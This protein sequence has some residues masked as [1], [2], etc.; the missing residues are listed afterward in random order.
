MTE[1]EIIQNSVY[2]GKPRILQP[3]DFL[4]GSFSPSGPSDIPIVLPIEMQAQQPA[5][6]AHGGNYLKEALD[7]IDGIS[8]HGSPEFLWGEIKKVDGFPI[9][10]GTS[11]N[12]ILKTMKNI[13]ICSIDLLPNNVNVSL[14]SYA[15]A[16]NIT[17]AMTADAANHKIGNYAFEN[18]PFTWQQL[19]QCISSHKA[20]LML[21][22]VGNEFYV[23]KDGTT[24]WDGGKILPLDPS[25]VISS[26]HFVLAFEDQDHYDPDLIYFYN[27]WSD[28]WG[29]KGLG[30]FDQN[31]LSRVLEIGTAVNI[32]DAR[33][34]TNLAYGMSGPQIKILQLFLISHGYSIPAG[35][36]GYYGQQ[37][38]TAIAM[39]QSAHGIIPTA[40]YN[41][42]PKTRAA[43]NVL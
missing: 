37:T 32:K 26:H 23:A 18:G 33:F 34:T 15:S 41:V 40:Q 20:V 3:T 11:M 13:G 17:Q 5:C 31:Y 22:A 24:T 30:Y 14:E 29:L 6:G 42:G 2:G 35:A 4:L 16:N 36:T 39:F 7:T 25:R 19:K 12:Y 27:E 8:F 10:D 21:L 43:L 1:E 38:A 28:T 9:E